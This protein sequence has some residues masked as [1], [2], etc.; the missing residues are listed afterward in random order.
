MKKSN[1]LIVFIFLA[2][3][4][5]FLVDYFS[6]DGKSK[7][8][9]EKSLNIEKKQPYDLSVFYET[10]KENLGDQYAEISQEKDGLR[11]IESIQK[12]HIL[13]NY[14]YIGKKLYLNDSQVSTIL[15]LMEMGN[16]VILSTESIPDNLSSALFANSE[17]STASIYEPSISLIFSHPQW[18][19]DT[20]LFE[21]KIKAHFSSENWNYFDHL[22]GAKE[23]HNSKDLVVVSA[24]N[25]TLP[26]CI[27]Y[28]YRGGKLLLHLN[29][30]LFSN[31][32]LT[33]PDGR[34]YLKNMMRHIPS[35]FTVFDRT[36]SLYRPNKIAGKSNKSIFDF[37]DQNPGLKHGWWI[38]LIGIGVF[39]LL[40]G[41][42]KQSSIPVMISPTNQSLSMIESLGHFYY[43]GRNYK[44]VFLKQWNQFNNFIKV[45]F[46]VTFTPGDEATLAK[47]ADKSGVSMNTLKQLCQNYESSINLSKISKKTLLESNQIL[48][49]FYTEYKKSH[50]K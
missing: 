23:D 29:P 25:S 22:I 7:F 2:L 27:E 33:Q 35:Q 43:S 42:R 47:I 24:I 19:N 12:K 6:E 31:L 49:A 13:F 28:N 15:H 3:S 14:F 5:G 16:T 9:W 30:A 46:Q 45:K 4:I 17:L 36:L 48:T 40:G 18:A 21:H 1:W 20:L 26:D 37:I 34:R 11:E 44:E 32:Y 8:N 39:L 50:G 38:L 41:K 10:L